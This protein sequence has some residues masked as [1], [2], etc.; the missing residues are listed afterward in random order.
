MSQNELA[1]RTGY[2]KG[3]WENVKV[4]SQTQVKS[5][6]H[7]LSDELLMQSY[8]LGEIEAFDE[9]YR[10]YSAKVYGYLMIKL[11]DRSQVD[12]LFQ[13]VFLKLHTARRSY[14][15]QYLFAPWLFAVCRSV[16]LDRL[17]QDK[18]MHQLEAEWTQ[19]PSIGMASFFQSSDPQS[20]GGPK[21][22]EDLD[23]DLSTLDERQKEVVAMRYLNEASFQ[24]MAVKLNTTPSNIRQIL[25]RAISSLRKVGDVK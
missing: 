1:N 21:K 6:I 5:E 9:L 24:E 16:F 14:E 11:R 25:S 17:R 2:Q 18:R 20:E 12:D 8:Q 7:E 4:K 10:R 3:C 13:A 23:V 15:R 19:D 22:V